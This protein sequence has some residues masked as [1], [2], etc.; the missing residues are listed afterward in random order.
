MTRSFGPILA[1]LI[2][3]NACADPTGSATDS[4]TIGR[5]SVARSVSEITIDFSTFGSGKEFDPD[6]YQSEGI[7]FPPEA[8]GPAGCVPWFIGFVVGD[9][10]LI[11][12]PTHGPV[13]ATFKKPISNLSL[14]FAPTFLGTATYTLSAFSPSGALVAT[15]SV[16]ITVDPADPADMGFGYFTIALTDLARPVKSFTFDN[17]LV[18]SPGPH[19]VIPYGVSSITYTR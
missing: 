10:A 13:S 16:T 19:V 4:S 14:S 18:R 8:C 12:D 6:F 17:V 2:G 5:A 9:A 1:L 3:L 15:T 11:G 7:V